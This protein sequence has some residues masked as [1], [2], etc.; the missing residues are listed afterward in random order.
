MF[1][2]ESILEYYIGFP[3]IIVSEKYYIWIING[4]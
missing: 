1:G 4:K 3:V 2:F